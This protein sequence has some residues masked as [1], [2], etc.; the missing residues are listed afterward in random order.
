MSEEYAICCFRWMGVDIRRRSSQI[1]NYLYKLKF[2]WRYQ[3]M[4]FRI[5]HCLFVIVIVL[6]D[7]EVHQY[8][9]IYLFS[10]V[11]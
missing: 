2:V 6:S 3:K 4:S 8:F 7:F 1:S 10:I 9:F 5:F 11:L